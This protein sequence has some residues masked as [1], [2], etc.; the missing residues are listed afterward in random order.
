M[1]TQ[2]STSRKICMQS[3]Y[4]PRLGQLTY[5]LTEETLPSCGVQYSLTV[6]LQK[7]TQTARHVTG[8]LELA[9]E[10]YW[11]IIRGLVTPYALLEVVQE[12]LP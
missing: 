11:K 9:M 5:T 4:H 6:Q 2:N 7:A 10:L 8:D 1:Q 3:R 12:L